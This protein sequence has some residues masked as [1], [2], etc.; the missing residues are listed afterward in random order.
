M[1]RWSGCGAACSLRGQS[2]DRCGEAAAAIMSMMVGA[3][4][5]F[6]IA[7][8]RFDRA[9]YSAMLLRVTALI[10]ADLERGAA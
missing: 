10:L 9:R 3:H 6:R 8:G 7:P 4:A 1:K 2:A 5:E